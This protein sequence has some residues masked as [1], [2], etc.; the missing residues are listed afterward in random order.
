MNRFEGKKNSEIA[1]LLGISVR[2]VETQIS[3]ALTALRTQLADYLSLMVL[4]AAVF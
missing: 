2:T 1:Q 3:K 4:V